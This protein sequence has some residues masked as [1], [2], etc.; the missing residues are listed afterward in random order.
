M[1]DDN[2]VTK[3]ELFAVG[4]RFTVLAWGFAYLYLAVQIIWPGSFTVLRRTRASAPGSSC[5]TSRSRP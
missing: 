3:D 2:W 5:S 1:F 4:R